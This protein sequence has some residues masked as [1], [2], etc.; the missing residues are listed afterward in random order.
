[1]SE[2]DVQEA[3]RRATAARDRESL[4]AALEPLRDRLTED[5]EVAAVWVEALRTSPTRATLVEEAEA[6]LD[7]W[8]EHPALVGGACDALIRAAERR[9]I[10][11]PPLS[12]GPASVA[13]Y[14]AERC[15]RKLP[16]DAQKDPAVGGRLLALR[17]NALSLLGPKRHADAVKTLERALRLDPDRGQWHFDLGLAHKRAGGFAASLEATRRARALLGDERGVLWNLAIA[18]TARGRGDEALEAWRA[19]GMPAS[20]REGALP[21][22][23]GLE[24][25]QVRLPTLGAGHG[26]APELPDEAAGFEIV[27]VQPLS[28]CHGVI[29]SPTFREA[30]ADFGD[31]ILWDAVPVGV[32][33][34]E[35]RPVPR[36]PF[37]GVL[38]RG[39][40]HRF[41]FLAMQQEAGQVRAL[42]GDL[43]EGVVFYEHGERVERVCPRCAAGDTMI[44]HE[45]LPAEEHRVA[46]GKIVVPGDMDL[47]GFARAL[48]EARSRHPGVLLAVPGLY[49]ALGDTPQAGKHHKR[50]GTIERVRGA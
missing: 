39:D 10:D 41:R 36:F 17:G 2:T 7:T 15:L 4:W 33:N 42:G 5:R 28:P 20:R 35:G 11:E 31:V 21:F 32:T 26:L 19:L 6:I 44:K 40:E 9:P 12:E 49:E 38:K 8:P 27:W 37:L 16:E 29:R 18:A 3:L 1:M 23:E 45:H 34:V 47:G 43:P 24:P 22:V 46:F 14:A 30:T 25:A 13:A 50:W 48:E